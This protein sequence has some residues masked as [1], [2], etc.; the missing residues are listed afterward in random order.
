MVFA[1]T[2]PVVVCWYVGAC[3]RKQPLKSTL[4]D[5]GNRKAPWSQVAVTLSQ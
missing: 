4:N 5:K 1:F 2:S 3:R